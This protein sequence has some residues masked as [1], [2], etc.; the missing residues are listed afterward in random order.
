[1]HLQAVINVARPF[2]FLEPGAPNEVLACCGRTRQ[3]EKGKSCHWH[4]THPFISQFTK[5]SWLFVDICEMDIFLKDWVY[6]FI[7][8]FFAQKPSGQ[9]YF[10]V[11]RL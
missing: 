1:M 11:S 6:L 10:Q 8:F 7:Y 9:R 4:R 5:K 2:C 3:K